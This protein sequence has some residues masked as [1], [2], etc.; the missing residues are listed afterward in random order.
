MIDQ[1]A[2]YGPARR[3]DLFVGFRTEDQ[4][5]DRADLRKLMQ[6]NPG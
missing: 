6:E 1:V 2:R 5:Y 4:I 3:V